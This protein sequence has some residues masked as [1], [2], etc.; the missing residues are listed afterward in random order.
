MTISLA[1]L[2]KF[3]H[4]GPVQNMAHKKAFC[5]GYVI[6]HLLQASLNT[7][8]SDELDPA[9]I[10]QAKQNSFNDGL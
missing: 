10:L 4:R 3:F 6:Y 7:E 9:A 5:K 1:I 2:W 8:I